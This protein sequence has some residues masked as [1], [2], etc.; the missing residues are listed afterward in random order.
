[1]AWPVLMGSLLAAVGAPAPPQPAADATRGSALFTAKECARCH[2]P[3]G[4]PGVGPPLDE[5]RR[6]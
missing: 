2:R 6:P 3:R 5:V 1:M 4:E